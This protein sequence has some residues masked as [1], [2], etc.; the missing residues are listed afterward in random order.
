[1]K[2]PVIAYEFPI[3]GTLHLDPWDSLMGPTSKLASGQAYFTVSG[4]TVGDGRTFKAITET[5]W[6]YLC[7]FALVFFI[8]RDILK[9]KT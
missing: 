3:G 9:Q 6:M 5:Y 1:V 4:H 2:P 7:Y 8:I